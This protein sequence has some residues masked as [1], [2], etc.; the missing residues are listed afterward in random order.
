MENL[1][2]YRCHKE[3]QA[4]KIKD[5]VGRRLLPDLPG[6][7]NRPILVDDAYLAKHN[8]Q[9]G[10]YYVV[11]DDG[12][13]SYSPAQAFESGYTRILENWSDL[14]RDEPAGDEEDLSFA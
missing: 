5:I 14:K 9:P 4:A 12:Y 13:A 1:P 8:P 11:Y 10:G 7:D 3:V 6:T 2:R